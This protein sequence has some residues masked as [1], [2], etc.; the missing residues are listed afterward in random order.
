MSLLL[1]ALESDANVAIEKLQGQLFHGRKL[2]LELGLKKERVGKNK[3]KANAEGA[4]VESEE[5]TKVEPVKPDAAA[6]KDKKAAA[7]A[8]VE[9]AAPA[10]DTHDGS[11]RKSR[12]VL[13]FGIP[14]DITKKQFRA[15]STRGYKKT[16]VDLLKEVH[17]IIQCN[18]R[19]ALFI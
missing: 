19:S 14:M 7:K 12:Q 15:I 2:I 10:A 16:E 13:I 5:Q 11:V 18:Y 9:A 17:N 3:E 1:S 6:K 8:K 4:E